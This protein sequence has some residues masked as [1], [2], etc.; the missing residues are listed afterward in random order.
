MI[1]IIHNPSPRQLT[2]F[3]LLWLA[4]FCLLG[5]LSWWKT[6]LSARAI[7]FWVIGAGISGIGLVWPRLLKV[8]FLLASYATFPIGLGASLLILVVIYYLL[9]TPLGLLL[10]C[11]GYDPMQ[12]LFNRGAKTYWSPHKQEENAKRYFQQF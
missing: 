4:C 9:V 1:P 10:R 7:A 8:V 11:M 3:G 12:R 6:G 5:G 2:V